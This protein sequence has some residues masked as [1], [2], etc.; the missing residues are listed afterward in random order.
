[1]SY[2]NDFPLQFY[3]F[4]DGEESA[5][6]QNIA[7]YVDILDEIKTNSAFYQDHYIQGGERPDQTAFMLYKNPHLHWTFYFMNDKIREQGWPVAY[8][9]VVKRVKS[10]YPDYVLT[11]QDSIHSILAIGDTITGAMS[12]AVGIIKYKNL[13]LGQI[14]VEVQGNVKFQQSEMVVSNTDIN[15]YV[16]IIAS[17]QGYLATHHYTMNGEHVDLD[18]TDMSVPVNAVPV[19]NLDFYLKDNDA[20]KQIRVIN[21]KEINAV[22]QLFKEALRS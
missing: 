7:V 1:M 5:L 14:Y 15:E 11:T 21:P 13:D 3:S 17:T 20:L 22:Q 2:F 18:L 16:D 19:T 4:G 10:D 6:V 12:Q 9:D 8:N